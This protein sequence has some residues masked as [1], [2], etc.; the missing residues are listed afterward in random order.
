MTCV[1]PS[2]LCVMSAIL[3]LLS[4]TGLAGCVDSA[5]PLLTDAQ[6]L[7]GERL[8]LM[9]YALRD[10][11]AHEPTAATFAWRA[12]RYMLI[13]GGGP[14]IRDFTLHRF[15]GQDLIVQSAKPAFPAEYA[16]ARKL[17]DG[18]Y[19][20]FPVDEHDAD[21]AIRGQFCAREPAIACRVATREA[22]LA[23]ARATAAKPHSTGGLAVLLAEH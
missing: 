1:L 23:L 10:G 21:Q 6:P 19:L 15:D 3:A 17:A 16:I 11:A 12:G 9:L 13:S 7:L 8:S 4:V 2:R 20:V 22:V 5:A 18:T 14:G